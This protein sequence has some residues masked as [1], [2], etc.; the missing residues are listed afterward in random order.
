MKYFIRYVKKS[1]TFIEIVVV[2]TIISLLATG[3]FLSYKLIINSSLDARRKSDI[4]QIR[5]ALE[6]YRNN[7]SS[8]PTNLT[9]LKKDSFNR[10]YLIEIPV[11]PK[12][13][14]PYDYKAIPQ[15]CNESTIFCT[16]YTITALLSNQKKYIGNPFGSQE[17][18]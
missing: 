5:I 3:S 17:T 14:T 9:K 8:Y 16:S 13:K 1:F 18:D 11:D 6:S 2:T 15:N 12:N 7:N 10:V 4:E